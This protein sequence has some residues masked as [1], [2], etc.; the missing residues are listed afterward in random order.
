MDSPSDMQ[1]EKERIFQI[2]FFYWRR[3]SSNER[4]SQWGDGLYH[5]GPSLAA[6]SPARVAQRVSMG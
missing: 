4:G 6:L 5:E 1:A 2:N 3:N